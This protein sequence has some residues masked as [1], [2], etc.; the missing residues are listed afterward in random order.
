M[1]DPPSFLVMN[2]DG[3]RKIAYRRLRRHSSIPSSHPGI[4]FIHGYLSNMATKKALALEESPASSGYR[5]YALIWK[6]PD[7]P[8]EIRD[9]LSLI[10]GWTTV[11]PYSTSLVMGH[12]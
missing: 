4:I 5:L 11:W 12:S 10:S 1:E 7:I 3:S 9:R 8:P 2:E 6:V